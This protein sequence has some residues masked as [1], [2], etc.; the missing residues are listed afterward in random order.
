M[1]QTCKIYNLL[2][3]VPGIFSAFLS[4]NIAVMHERKIPPTSYPISN[5]FETPLQTRVHNDV[6]QMSLIP[7]LLD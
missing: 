5:H 2:L 3:H 1:K 7:D 4:K 6:L